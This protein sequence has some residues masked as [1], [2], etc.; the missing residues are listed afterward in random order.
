MFISLTHLLK[1]STS[2]TKTREYDLLEFILVVL[3]FEILEDDSGFPDGYL[4]FFEIQWAL[5]C[6]LRY[7]FGLLQLAE[8]ALLVQ[9]AL[10]L[11]KHQKMC[12]ALHLF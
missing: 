5:R 8:F 3:D 2:C 7:R 10:R 11:A 9:G 6:A 4:S 1:L 12:A